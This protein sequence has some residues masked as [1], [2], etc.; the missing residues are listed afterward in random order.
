MAP[1]FDKIKDRLIASLIHRR[2]QQ[3]GAELRQKA[4]RSSIQ[5]WACIR[6]GA[7]HRQLPAEAAPKHNQRHTAWNQPAGSD[8]HELPC[9]FRG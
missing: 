1:P 9:P 7:S 6:E 2:A 4:S 5:P 8:E 3:I